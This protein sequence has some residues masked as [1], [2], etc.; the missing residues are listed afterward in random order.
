MLSLNA[1]VTSAPLFE[2]WRDQ[3]DQR[4][5]PASVKLAANADGTISEGHGVEYRVKVSSLLR[6]AG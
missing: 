1:L 5:L 3:K 2:I 6:N 4:Y